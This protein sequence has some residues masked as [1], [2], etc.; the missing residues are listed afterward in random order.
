MCP[1]LVGLENIA[2][3]LYDTEG[4]STLEEVAKTHTHKQEDAR[5]H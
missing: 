2:R 3:H 5:A 4:N 1:V